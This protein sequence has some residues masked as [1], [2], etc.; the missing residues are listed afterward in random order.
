MS[1]EINLKELMDRLHELRKKREKRLRC[2]ECGV[3]APGGN[4]V[5]R[6]LPSEGRFCGPCW[7]SG[8]GVV[9]VVPADDIELVV[10]AEGLQ[11]WW[12]RRELLLELERLVRGVWVDRSV[13]AH[14]DRSSVSLYCGQQ[15]FD[16]MVELLSELEGFQEK[17][18]S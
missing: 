2:P 15:Q 1:N 14:L 5:F 16:R 18:E 3:E 17:A 8:R 11:T 6:Y 4:A 9:K 7:E 12:R 13:M 10:P